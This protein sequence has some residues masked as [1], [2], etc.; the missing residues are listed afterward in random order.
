MKVFIDA[1]PNLKVQSSN[2]YLSRTL[3]SSLAQKASNQKK[4]S[5]KLLLSAASELSRHCANRLIKLESAIRNVSALM[6]ELTSLPKNRQNA[7]RD[8]KS[9][10]PAAKLDLFKQLLSCFTHYFNKAELDDLG[11][12]FHWR[13]QSRALQIRGNQQPVLNQVSKKRGRK[14]L[15]QISKD[16]IT[17]TFLDPENVSEGMNRPVKKAKGPDG[18]PLNAKEMNGSI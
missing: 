10:V 3:V 4:D 12:S 17:A 9:R 18:L 16:R 5:V 13:V 11:F 7:D 14:S 6:N 15:D 1:L 8:K 2:S